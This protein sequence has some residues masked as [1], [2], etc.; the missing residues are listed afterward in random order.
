MCVR[1]GGG[2][3]ITLPVP[4]SLEGSGVARDRFGGNGKS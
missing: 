3:L 2:G 4:E 1:D